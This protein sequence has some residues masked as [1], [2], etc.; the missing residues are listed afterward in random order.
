MD[1]IEANN[2]GRPTTLNR[3]GQ[4]AKVVKHADLIF[5]VLL[6]LLKSKNESIR[7]GT[8]RTL[9][10]KIIPD[11]KAVQIE[12]QDNHPIEITF[13]AQKIPQNLSA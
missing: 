6:G 13:T 11:L 3:Q 12:A 10:D 9:L 4:Y 8:A 5:N 7:L 2:G 1:S